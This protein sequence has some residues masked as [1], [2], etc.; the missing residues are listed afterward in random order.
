MTDFSAV[1]EKLVVFFWTWVVIL[2]AN[3]VV[4]FGACFT[5]YCLAAALPHTL[6]IAGVIAFF[7]T[8]ENEEEKKDATGTFDKKRAGTSGRFDYSRKPDVQKNRERPRVR[9]QESGS[10][11]YV[12]TSKAY[13]DAYEKYIGMKL[14]ERGYIVIYNGF[15]NG[16]EDRG[17]D[18]IALSR[19]KR[20]V[21]LVQCK[22]WHR[23]EMKVEHVVEVYDKLSA[24]QALPDF[25]DISAQQIL[26]YLQLNDISRNVIVKLLDD[27]AEDIREYT[28]RKTLY[29]ATEL[30][31][32][33]AVGRHLKMIK[34]DIFR[35]KDMKIVFE[36]KQ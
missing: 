16:Y 13:G 29:G 9:Q 15:I 10:R 5:P 24:Y 11:D 20:I 14:E 33:L 2:V 17:V 30:V 22:N 21:N 34:P 25:F 36:K 19:K 28:F 4:L 26:E 32:D 27:V 31:V 35:Y 1:K 8:R 7:L 3:Q 12:S 18:L 6:V 23:K